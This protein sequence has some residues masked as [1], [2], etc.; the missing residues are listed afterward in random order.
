MKKRSIAL[1]SALLVGLLGGCVINKGEGVYRAPEDTHYTVRYMTNGDPSSVELSSGNSALSDS[2]LFSKENIE[3]GGKA[4]A[5][6]SAPQR[7]GYDFVGWSLNK[8]GVELYDFNNAVTSNVTLYAKWERSGDII[9]S[10]Y[11]EPV[12]TFKEKVDNSVNGVSLNGVLNVPI[13]NGSVSL[14]TVGI[15]KLTENA[16]NVKE[17][18]NYT[19]NSS[20][21]ITSATFA[22]NTIS[23][24]YTYGGST[25]NV[26]VT[27]K[28][29]TASLNVG[30]STYESKAVNY[31]KKDIAPYK[32]ILGGS[33]SME[34]WTSS[35]EDMDPVTTLN[36]GI[37]GTT[38][39]HW[40]NYLAQRLI[41]PYSPRAV[42]LYVG[43]NNIIN[44]SKTGTQTGD[45]LKVLFDDI[46]SHLPDTTIYYVLINLVP[47][48][49]K[50]QADIEKSNSMVA[51]YSKG[52]DWMQLIDAGKD[53]LKETG[54][55]NS[56]YFRTD[57]LHMTISGY[58]IWGKTI[59]DYF[60][61]HEKSIW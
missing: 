12:L 40:S 9:S 3:K 23:L 28:N 34:F 8:N 6:T 46:H 45:A 19:I 25:S 58:S 36:V 11:V 61:E 5:P 37:G 21:T 14:T 2:V 42:V 29:I 47:G 7:N 52:K 1:A 4:T 60:V 15:R 32:V 18:L 24:A 57:G 39:E 10:E 50:Y 56:A 53:L 54:K 48:Y 41:Y 17:L 43:I 55:P 35:K 44:N 20:A 33:S 16:D 59:K 22:L 30:N 51:E 31:E 38:V 49:M 26:S 13:S 27:V